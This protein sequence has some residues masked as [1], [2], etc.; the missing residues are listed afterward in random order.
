LQ[1]D[2]F[3]WF[4]VTLIAVPLDKK[5]INRGNM[6][7]SYLNYS[8]DKLINLNYSLNKE[9]LRTSRTGGYSSSTII[10]CNTRKYHGLLVLPQ[11]DVDG[12]RH[13]LLSNVDEKLIINDSEFNLSARIYPNGYIFPKGHKYIRAFSSE[14]NMKLSYRIG[15]TLFDKEY[16]FVEKQSRLLMKYTL[17]DTQAKSI[18]FRISPLLAYR[19]IHTVTQA[20]LDISHRYEPI[21]NG[22]SWQLYPGYSRLFFQVS[23]NAE[24]IHNPD[25]H[26]NIEY[27]GEKDRGYEFNEDLFVPGFF[28]I[29]LK[30]NESVVISIGLEEK[31]PS[32]FKRSFAAELN[33]RFVRDSYENCLRNA[34]DQFLIHR[35]GR[36]EIIA[37]YH[38]YGR[39]GRISFIALPGICLA[40]CNEAVFHGVMEN[41]IKE[42]KNGHFANVISKEQLYYTSLDTAFWFFRALHKYHQITDGK[43]AIWKNYGGTIKQILESFRNFEAGGLEIHDNGLIHTRKE[44]EAIS[45]MDAIVDGKPVT[46]RQGYLVEV[47]ALWYDALKFFLEQAEIHEDR[48]FI[49]KWKAYPE[50]IERSFSEIFWNEKKGYLADYVDGDYKNWTIRPNMIFAMSE[51]FSPLSSLQKEYVLKKVVDELLTPRGLRS[52]SPNDPDYQGKCVGDQRTRDLAAHQGTAWPWLLGAFAEAYLKLHKKTGKAYVEKIYMGF[53]EEMKNAGVGTV[54]EIYDGN[55]PYEAKGAISHAGSVAELLR[56]K[57]MLDNRDKII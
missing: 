36:D 49:K 43:A 41:L 45:W 14:P 21:A 51:T 32:G 53:E 20:N 54:S 35:Y 50:K 40:E 12:G 24:Y 48:T 31:I 22:A 56:I 30:K 34:A 16:V 3:D 52:L 46:D 57:W 1:L 55:P 29:E 39:W 19:S 38:W 18:T 37:G 5:T 28:D 9:L 42:L 23:K 11:P 2:V 44:G 13:V 47:N 15:N 6:E 8:K 4:P 26:F 10:G 17:Q 25:W 27:P 7:S 33:K